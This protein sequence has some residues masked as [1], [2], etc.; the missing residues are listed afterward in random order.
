MTK[1]EKAV[2]W[3]IN[4]AD[5]NS[6]GYAWGGWGPQDYDCGHAII[7]AFEQA[8]IP[9]KSKGATYTGNMY[10]AMMACG[11][12]DVTKQCNLATGAGMQRG[13]VLLN[14]ADHTAMFIGGGRVV[15][16]RSAEGNIQP[17]D[18]SGNEIRTQSYW[19]YPWNYVLR[20][21]A[22]TGDINEEGEKHEEIL[23]GYPHLHYGDG[24]NDPLQEVA[25]WQGHLR[26][27]GY[28]LDTDGEFGPDTLAKTMAWQAEIGLEPTGEIG[29]EEWKQ[30]IFIPGYGKESKNE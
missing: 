7:T 11:F 5:D 1:T 13:D 18:Q 12:T 28:I 20:P 19:N 16:A 25:N 23:R 24:L 6:H 30:V 2:L 8:G 29:D 26:L 4:L 15:H 10:P 9:V 3:M 27:W 17:G 14:E 21:P 22:E